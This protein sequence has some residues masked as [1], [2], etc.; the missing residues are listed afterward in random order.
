M[1]WIINIIPIDKGWFIREK[2]IAE[3]IKNKVIKFCIIY[4][5]K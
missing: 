1:V 2:E 5:R 3:I 4:I